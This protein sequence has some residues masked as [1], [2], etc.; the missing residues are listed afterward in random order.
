MVCWAHT[1]LV[2]TKL[3]LWATVELV[4]MLGLLNE[5]ELHTLLHQH[6]R[7]PFKFHI[8]L[9]VC[10]IQIIENIYQRRI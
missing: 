3:Y 7:S 5:R 8:F 6:H 1:Q 9:S 10:S 2:F 4:H